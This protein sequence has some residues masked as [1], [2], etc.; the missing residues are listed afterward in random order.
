M[1]FKIPNHLSKHFGSSCIWLLRETQTIPTQFL[2]LTSLV[3]ERYLKSYQGLSTINISN[4]FLCQYHC[5]NIWLQSFVDWTTCHIPRALTQG[6][7]CSK[8]DKALHWSRSS[9]LV[10]VSQPIID[11]SLISMTLEKYSNTQKQLHQHIINH[12]TQLL[13]VTVGISGIVFNRNSN[14]Q[15]SQWSVHGCEQGNQLYCYHLLSL[16]FDMLQHDCLLNRSTELTGSN[17]T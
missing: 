7:N 9:A 4:W 13:H 1:S 2:L 11:L 15:G 6:Q 16:L 17:H 8:S 3:T 10:P 5:S 14:D 12:I